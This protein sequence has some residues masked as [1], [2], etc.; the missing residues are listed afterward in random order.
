MIFVRRR[1]W[2]TVFFTGDN[3]VP[4][5]KYDFVI[6]QGAIYAVTI[7]WKDSS[8]NPIN[9]STYTATMKGKESK[10]T[11]VELFSLTSTPAAGIVLGGAAGTIAITITAAVTAAFKFDIAVYDLKMKKGTDDP[12]RLLE[13]QITLSK[14]VTT[15]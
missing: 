15:T 13:G 1:D 2:I 3:I 10:D 6:E 5:G 4:A 11:T 7:T 9:L 12:I 8:G 14:E